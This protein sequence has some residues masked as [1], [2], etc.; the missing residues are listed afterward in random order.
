M[1][2]LILKRRDCHIFLIY[3]NICLHSGEK[4]KTADG[5]RISCAFLYH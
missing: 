2:G 5:Q 3:S 4:K 1:Y